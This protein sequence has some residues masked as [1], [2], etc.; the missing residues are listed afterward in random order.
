VH[1][2]DAGQIAVI[3]VMIEPG[4]DNPAFDAVWDYLPSADNRERI[5]RASVNAANL[6]PSDRSYFRYMGSFTPPPCTEDVLWMV[7]TTPVQLSAG[8]IEKFQAIIDGNNRP[9]QPLN[10]RKIL[11]SAD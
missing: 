10:G 8:Q 3:G 4:A 1:K 5:E 6:L 2:T 11:V 7:L 9:I